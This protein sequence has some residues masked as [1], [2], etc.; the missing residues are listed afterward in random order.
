MKRISWILAMCALSQMAFLSG[1]EDDDDDKPGKVADRDEDRDDKDLDDQDEPMAG[2]GQSEAGDEDEGSADT[3]EP[4]DEGDDSE[5]EADILTLAEADGHFTRLIA[6]LEQTGLDDEL[7][8]EGPFTVLAPND[9]A[10]EDFE[11]EYPGMLELLSEEELSSWLRYHVIADRELKADDLTDGQLLKTLAE[12]VVKVE[13]SGDAVEINGVEVETADIEASNG[14]VHVLGGI[15]MPPQDLV[16]VLASNDDFEQIVSAI[17]AAGLTETLQGEGPFTVFAPTDDAFD[18][19][20]ALPEGDALVNVLRYHV[21]EGVSGPL[22]LKDG[23]VV[24]T[25]EGSPVVFE[26][27]EDEATINGIAITETNV[28]ARNGVVHIIDAV[29]TPPTEDIVGAATSAGLTTLATLIAQQG[30]T[31]TLQGEGPFTVFAPSEEAFAGL[32]MVPEGDAL[33][34]V[35]RYH[36]IGELKGSGDLESGELE[37]A[38]DKA[39]TVDIEDGVT[40]NGESEVTMAN[41]VAT[42]GVIHVI[43]GVLIPPSD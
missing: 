39:L 16:G 9:E 22:D 5:V 28:V 34:D 4:E 40:L 43:D 33:T 17:D 12:T 13:L 29:M 3:D 8:G 7:K 24:K 35:L 19:L 31:E 21:L 20:E 14:V 15:L 32:E 23:G 1:C 30:L 38:A 27:G 37:T 26:F 10:F 6:A 2:S 11:E 42:N 41:I 36:V 18:M 25:V